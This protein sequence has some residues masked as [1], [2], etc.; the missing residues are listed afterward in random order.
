MDL[1]ALQ[2]QGV[3]LVQCTFVDNA[4]VTRVKVVPVG[5]LG[6]VAEHGVGIS[7]VFA[8]FAVDDHIAASPGFDGPV[9]DMRLLPDLDATVALA[10]APGYAW[11]PVRQHDQDMAVMPVCQRSLLERTTATAA[12]QGLDFKM[13]YEVEFTLFDL[14]D[15]PVHTGPGY[16]PRALLEVEGFALDLV[17][18][19]Q[20]Q[21]IDVDQFHPEYALGQCEVSVAPSDPVTA[22]DRYVLLRTTVTQVAKRHLL[23]VSFA[24]TAVAGQVGNGCHLHLSAWRDGRNMMTGGDGAAG[25]T[26]EGEALTAGVLDHLPSLSGVL[27]PSAASYARLQPSSWA[28]AFA[29][30]GVENREAALRFIPGSRGQ[31]DR[32]ANVELKSIDGAAN[33]YL[34][35][36]LVIGAAL[37]G[38]ERGLRL[39]SPTQVDPATLPD[40]HRLASDLGE[41]IR[42]LEES[43]FV[44]AQ[45]GDPLFE[46][47][48]AVRRLEWETYGEASD[49]EL[50]AAHRWRY[51]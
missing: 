48:L 26:A 40:A 30:W 5:R 15:R 45:F 28:G 22:A 41:A 51:G 27:T 44:R 18:A 7:Y 29:C 31:R 49:D 24:P 1:R 50:L 16:S 2:Q 23:R 12:E 11:A 17:E 39:P 3:R 13:T 34:A 14:E 20:A 32:A 9:G 43:K 36:A 33:A 25:M 37:D 42:R 47:F 8:V 10:A 4:G 19:L 46:A 35:A 21:G 38:L 6:S